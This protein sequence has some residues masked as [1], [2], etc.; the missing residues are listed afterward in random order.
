M[1]LG[2]M[3]RKRARR[4]VIAAAQFDAQFL[5]DG[6]LNVIHVA[7]V[8]DGLEDAV[9]ES[10]RQNILHGFFAQVMIDAEDLLLSDGVQTARD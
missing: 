9:R 3:S 10:K 5:G 6:D 8:P 2:T 4:V 1:W 7:P